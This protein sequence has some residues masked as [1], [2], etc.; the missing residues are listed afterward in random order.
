MTT[1]SSKEN[2]TIL[3]VDDATINLDIL[4]ETLEPEGYDLGFAT[5]G[6]EALEIIPNLSPDLILL[7]VMMPGIDGYETCRRLKS[8]NATK[9]IPVIFI[10]TKG[11]TEDIVKG[12][13]VGGV[14]YILKPFQKEEVCA[15]V[16][17]HLELLNLRQSLEKE[18]QRVKELLEKT[19]NGSI[20]LLVEILSRFDRELFGK[21]AS[22]KKIIQY[23]A[24]KLKIK[25]S[26]EL[27]AA[28]MLS[29]IGHVVIPPQIIFK[30][31]EGKK[32]PPEEQAIVTSFPEAGASLLSHIPNLKQ[33]SKIILYQNKRFD[34][35]GFHVD[36]VEGKNIPLGARIFKILWDLVQLESDG[37]PRE[38][39]MDRLRG[40]TGWYDTDIMEKIFELLRTQEK[41]REAKESFK[42]VTLAELQV[43]DVFERDLKSVAGKVLFEAG[44]SISRANLALLGNYARVSWIGVQEP[45]YIQNRAN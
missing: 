21:A 1:I 43:G 29:Q 17:T 33:V 9:D 25:D 12:F 45:I 13:Q 34:G 41:E 15:R 26:W 7:D 2:W 4:R 11:E 16:E 40:K 35:G 5:T 22:L 28:S 27:E 20:G 30:S 23:L 31:R 3:A 14:D 42:R 19:L 39:A 38:K 8:N 10:T 18:N 32:L 37:T 24:K 36:E 6:K 44:D